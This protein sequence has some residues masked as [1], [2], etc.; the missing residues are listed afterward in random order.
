MIQRYHYL[1]YT[2]LF[3]AK[4]RYVIGSDEGYLGAMRYSASAWK[5]APRDQFIGWSDNPRQANL[6][7]VICNS[8]F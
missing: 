7:C 2:P 4:L 5:V 8:R 3:G 6:P 1:G